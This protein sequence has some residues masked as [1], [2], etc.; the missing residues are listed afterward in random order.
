M[1]TALIR[2]FT[3]RLPITAMTCGAPVPGA[4]IFQ[5]NWQVADRWAGARRF[6]YSF[7]GGAARAVVQ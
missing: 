5:A 3:P 1:I 7:G 2:A 6:P 4:Y